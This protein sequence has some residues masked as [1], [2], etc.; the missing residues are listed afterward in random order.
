MDHLSWHGNSVGNMKCVQLPLFNTCVT[1]KASQKEERLT[2]RRLS[3][4][5]APFSTTYREIHW[6]VSV[7]AHS[8]LLQKSYIYTYKQFI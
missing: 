4:L 8:T 7:R 5:L 1:C 6:C 2:P 3:F